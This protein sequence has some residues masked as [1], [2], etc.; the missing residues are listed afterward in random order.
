M[1]CQYLLTQSDT[2]IYSNKDCFHSS[3]IDSKFDTKNY[4]DTNLVEIISNNIFNDV[5]NI[6]FLN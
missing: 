1:K 4:T 2:I 3:I 5:I 6:I